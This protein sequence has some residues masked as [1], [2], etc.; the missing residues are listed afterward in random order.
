MLEFVSSIVSL[1][2][3]F[4][5]LTFHV[6]VICAIVAFYREFRV[7]ICVCVFGI[8]SACV[9]PTKIN[10]INDFFFLIPPNTERCVQRMH[11]T[12]CSNISMVFYG[13]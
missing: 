6:A 8:C 9:I 7:C 2:S 13:P 4:N 3:V 1:L 10:L 12:H 11:K 5:S